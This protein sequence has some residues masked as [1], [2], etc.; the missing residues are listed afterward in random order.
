MSESDAKV[1]D[2]DGTPAQATLLAE[3]LADWLLDEGIVEPNP[4]RDALW[5]PSEWVPGP[6]WRKAVAEPRDAEPRDRGHSWHDR[7]SGVGFANRGVDLITERR[8]HDPGGNFESPPC[9]ICRTP[10]DFDRYVELIEVW[11]DG[12]EPRL[13]CSRCRSECLIGDWRWRF[14]FAVGNFAVRF[15]NWPIL[16]DAFVEEIARHLSSRW[17]LILGHY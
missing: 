3:R 2:L 9:P 16:D 14:G 17:T 13:L 4:Q 11:L 8:V 5:Q 10:A 7:T 15:N 12:P 6:H 1:V